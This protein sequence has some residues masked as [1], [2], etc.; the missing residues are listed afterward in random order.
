MY[1]QTIV[2]ALKWDDT[3]GAST[4]DYDLLLFN[5]S[6]Q[7]IAFSASVQDGD[8]DPYEA[9]SYTATYNGTY[10]IAIGKL[11]PAAAVNFHLYSYYHDWQYQTAS[12]SFLVPADSFSAVAVG[13]VD[14]TTPT[15]LES[16][17]SHGPTDDGRVKP[18]L[19]APDGVS[20]VSYG[21]DN[22][23]GTS[24]SAPHVAGAAALVKER[25]SS[26][27]P[28]QIQSFLEGR[29]ID[30]GGAGK[31]NL[32]GSGRLHLGNSGNYT[33]TMSV[34]Y[35]EIIEGVTVY[36]QTRHNAS[37]AKAC[38][39][40]YGT[41]YEENVGG[42]SAW[43][44]LSHTWTTN[45][46]TGKA[47][48]WDEIN[49]LE[50]GVALNHAASSPVWSDC[51]QVYA[52]VKYSLDGVQNVVTLRPSG[53]DSEITIDYTVSSG[54]SP[55]IHYDKV[56]EASADDVGSYL[57]NAFGTFGVFER[58]LFIIPDHE[59]C[60]GIITPAIGNHVYPEGATV[61]I[62]AT[63]ASGW[64]FTKWTGD[65]ADPY[66]ANT[67]IIMGSDKTV[68]AHFSRL[69]LSDTIV[70][71]RNYGIYVM[72][73]DGSNQTVVLNDG[74]HHYGPAISPDC[75]RIAYYTWY[76]N[77]GSYGV[78][79]IYIDGSNKIQLTVENT[80][81]SLT[82][83][84]YPVWSPDGTKIAFASLQSY[85]RIYIMNSDGSNKTRVTPLSNESNINPSW[86]PDGARIAFTSSL[87]GGDKEIYI[88]NIDGSNRTNLT[89]HS[90]ADDFEP[91]WSPDGTKIAFVRYGFEPQVYIMNADGSTPVKLT[92][93]PIGARG[94]AWSPDGSK[95]AFWTLSDDIYV[96]NADGSNQIRISGDSS[97]DRYPS[98][99]IYE[100][101]RTLTMSINGSGSVVPSTGSHN[102]AV[103][104][105]VNITATSATNWEF[106]NW[107]GD[108]SDNTSPS[109]TVAM[110]ANKS[111][112]AN[113]NRI[114]S[115]LKT[116]VS[117]SGDVTPA[118]GSYTYP[119]GETVNVTA[120]AATN[121]AFVNWGGDVADNTSAST[122][123]TM[124]WDKTVTA[125]FNR[126]ASTL[127]MVVSGS[128]NVTPVVGNHTYA[129]GAT[130]NITATPAGDGRFVNWTGDVGT[131]ADVNSASTNVTMDTDKT[132]TANFSQA[133]LTM[134]VSGSGSVTPAVG[135]H[136]YPVGATVNISATPA[137]G[138][139]FSGWTGDVA[140]ANSATT[141]MTMDTDKTV[142]ANFSEIP[143]TVP[144]GGGGGGGGGGGVSAGWTQFPDSVASNGAFIHDVTA[145]SMDKKC[146]L[147]IKHGTTGLDKYARALSRITIFEVA[148]PPEGNS[149]IGTVYDLGPE[150]TTF[151]PPITLTMSYDPEA[152]PEGISEDYLYIAYWDGAQWIALDSMVDSETNSVSVEVSHFTEFSVIGQPPPPP[153]P[154]PP[155]PVV[156]YR[157]SFEISSLTIYPEEVN[158]GENVNIAVTV[159][160]TGN[161]AGSYEVVLKFD[162]KVLDTREIR[163]ARGTSEEVTFST[164]ADTPGKKIFE[165]NG[166]LGS[167]I[168]A[169]EVTPPEQIP[170]PLDEPEVA[171]ILDEE[172]AP[173]SET[174]W[175]VIGITTA[176][177]VI[178]AALLLYFTWWRK[179]GTPSSTLREP[180]QD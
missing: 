180:H 26:Y 75:T 13:A 31:D 21:T 74:K 142:T 95:I 11:G 113:F 5:N 44:T 27:T 108:V 99:G 38:L 178:L 43:T 76:H 118:A 29:A 4:N 33:L 155:K 177:F 60:G 52:E 69:L 168:V 79:R 15:T 98:W 65:I 130:V 169:G 66:S 49:A 62:T 35:V 146:V 157:A 16:F 158:P 78:D 152:L 117:G 145:K 10:F 105:T 167:F 153:P 159:T 176:S 154:P 162:G 122:N 3:W 25:F 32:Y 104:A 50:I 54:G 144:S 127:T 86:S 80:D 110:D 137:S 77:Y 149:I 170:L 136:T 41:V 17:S 129:V 96:M 160:N 14:Y 61:N 138:W 82:D 56:N 88:I 119:I 156:Q 139:Q 151:E 51:T 71:T 83:C 93:L 20:T 140:D 23:S 103:S 101:T 9:L 85:D 72:N 55:L 92:S 164:T 2:A 34:S 133:T 166:L 100:P 128:G 112:T 8:D 161:I 47:W 173:T 124:N 19:V 94:P 64:Q 107:T 12:S 165:I 57:T 39:K 109:T 132:I 22:F 114:T 91:A 24:A 143:V 126:V 46:Y 172:P 171:P 36:V 179:R 120:T 81:W 121:W 115:I 67:T 40:T 73:S 106:V 84:Y 123:V 175:W 111:V 174:N 48:T 53:D 125:N 116:A 70:F 30:L 37:S 102:Y 89:S 141:S 163:L 6:A 134:A 150:G 58:D 131:V 68:T 147:E 7:L 59:G 1:G 63:P 148:E 87:Y 135:S 90:T 45:P 97:N 42:Y 18:D 28:T